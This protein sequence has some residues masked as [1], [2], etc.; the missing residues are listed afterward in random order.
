MDEFQQVHTCSSNWG[1]DATAWPYHAPV[2]EQYCGSG[3]AGY[4][5]HEP[6]PVHTAVLHAPGPRGVSAGDHG[7]L[8]TR[9]IKS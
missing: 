8:A 4:L 3:Q 9:V 6:T 5:P 1:E 7:T 2:L